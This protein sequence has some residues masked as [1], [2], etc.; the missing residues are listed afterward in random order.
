VRAPPGGPPP[1]P[2][3]VAPSAPGSAVPFPSVPAVLSALV[4]VA[5]SAPVPVAPSAP[6]PVAP[7]APVPVAPSAPVPPHAEVT[8]RPTQK[9]VGGAERTSRR[10][11]GGA[12]SFAGFRAG[13]QNLERDGLQR[14]GI[15]IRPG[16]RAESRSRSGGV[17]SA[18]RFFSES[19]P[20]VDIVS[21][22][23][24]H[25]EIRLASAASGPQQADPAASGPQQADP[26][27]SGPQQGNRSTNPRGRL[28][29][30][31]TSRRGGGDVSVRPIQGGVGVWAG[32]AAGGGVT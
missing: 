25:Y 18:A 28:G 21:R 8:V 32:R 24:V 7:S 10:G 3:P 1:W 29:A 9:E 17:T 4:P 15:E 16:F 2:V 22:D 5:P 30:E 19:E 26:A 31:R 23:R 27:A 20:K 11:G 13:E 6:V 14:I 12:G